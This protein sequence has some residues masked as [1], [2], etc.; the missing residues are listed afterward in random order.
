MIAHALTSILFSVGHRNGLRVVTGQ[1]DENDEYFEMHE[2]PTHHW[3]LPVSYIEY[4]MGR[5]LQR[6]FDFSSKVFCCYCTRTT[7]SIK[8]I[9]GSQECGHYHGNTFRHVLRL[10]S[11]S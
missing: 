1:S 8:R 11:S 9:V 5:A 2:V 3:G 7:H 4:G 10:A 6:A